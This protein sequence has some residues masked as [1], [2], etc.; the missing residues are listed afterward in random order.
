VKEEYTISEPGGARGV[1]MLAVSADSESSQR[2]HTAPSPRKQRA[3]DRARRSLND[4]EWTENNGITQPVSIHRFLMSDIG[5]SYDAA[6]DTTQKKK[7]GRMAEMRSKC[8]ALRD[9]DEMT[10]LRM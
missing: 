2:V 8:F 10:R 1:H 7:R 3:Y 9:T 4:Y 5:D 6:A